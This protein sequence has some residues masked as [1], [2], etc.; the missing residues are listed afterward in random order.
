MYYYIYALAV[1]ILITAQ[2][3]ETTYET[4]TLF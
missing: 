4:I 1:I 3:K 2:R